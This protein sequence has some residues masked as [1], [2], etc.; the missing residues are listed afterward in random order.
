M[1]ADKCQLNY[2]TTQRECLGMFW[3]VLVLRPYLKGTRFTI[4]VGQD[5]WKC[6]LSLVDATGRL[7]RWQLRLSEFEFDVV[8]R[9]DIKH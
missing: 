3:S 8:H 6:T 9:A 7:A 4:R 1:I 5:S 2:N